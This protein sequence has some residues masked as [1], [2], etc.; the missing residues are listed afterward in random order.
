M[1]SE[2]RVHLVTMEKN[3]VSNVNVETEQN[4]TTLRDIVHVLQDGEDDI[5]TNVSTESNVLFISKFTTHSGQF[6]VYMY[7]FYCIQLVFT[8][9]L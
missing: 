4:V 3:A 7:V 9:E 1:S 5:V 6:C 2:Q 8:A